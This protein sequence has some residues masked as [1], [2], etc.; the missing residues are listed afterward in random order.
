MR[1]ATHDL[2]A[3]TAG[4]G[5]ALALHATIP[6]TAILAGGTYATARLPDKIESGIFAKHRV[7]RVATI[8]AAGAVPV[9]AGAPLAMVPVV[10][11]LYPLRHRGPLTHDPTI[12][13]PLLELV[14]LVAWLA[15]GPWAELAVTTVLIAWAAHLLLDGMTIDGLPLVLFKRKVHL[16]PEG[17]RIRV[18]KREEPMD[19]KERMIGAFLLLGLLLI[20]YFIVTT[21]IHHPP[22]RPT[23]TQAA[24][25]RAAIARTH[26]DTRE[27]RR[28]LYVSSWT[29]RPS[30]RTAIVRSHQADGAELVTLTCRQGR[31][32]VTEAQTG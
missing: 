17:A 3:L 29:T 26:R 1:G 4:A 6:Q 32:H 16:M 10:A 12:T 28:D 7:L 25:R 31:W 5:A 19:P 8:G 21:W 18:G 24:A 2:G 20:G 13:L 22:R 15:G 9:M 23:C 14:A 27:P 30:S 11:L